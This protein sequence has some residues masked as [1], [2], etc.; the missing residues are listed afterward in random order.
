MRSTCGTLCSDADFRALPITPSHQHRA[1][2]RCMAVSKRT[3]IAA[4]DLS[5]YSTSPQ[6]R[7]DHSQSCDLLHHAC[8]VV[9]HWLR[10]TS[11]SLSTSASSL[12]DTLQH[13]AAIAPSSRSLTAALAPCSS[14]RHTEPTSCRPQR[15][16]INHYSLALSSCDHIRLI[17]AYLKV[18]EL[19][20]ASALSH[21]LHRMF[22]SNAAWQG[23]LEKALNQA[24][25]EAPAPAANALSPAQLLRCLCRR[26]LRRPRSADRNL[27]SEQKWSVDSVG[28]SGSGRRAAKVD[29]NITQN[30]EQDEKSDT[31]SSL[32]MSASEEAIDSGSGKQRYI[33]LQQCSHCSEHVHNRCYRLLPLVSAWRT[34]TAPLCASCRTLIDAAIQSAEKYGFASLTRINR[35]T[36]EAHCSSGCKGSSFRVSVV[37]DNTPLEDVTTAKSRKRKVSLHSLSSP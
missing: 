31:Q 4:G 28:K 9:T 14:S 24:D 23:R 32:V 22:D 17:A 8:N 15:H 27:H 1:A 29:D 19:I 34:H 10:V 5:T 13:A 26:C 36:D 20:T 21:P 2:I 37:H 25:D 3:C 7:S 16:P 6:R 33:D 11:P 30:V 35:T 12:S 18:E